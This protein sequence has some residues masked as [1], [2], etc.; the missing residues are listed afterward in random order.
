M[1]M[2]IEGNSFSVI[3]Y[4]TDA[5]AK[6][7]NSKSEAALIERYKNQLELYARALTEILG[8]SCNGKYIYSFDLSKLIEI[9]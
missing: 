6:Y 1:I 2:S 4:K 9:K 7:G 8:I 3:D 5:V